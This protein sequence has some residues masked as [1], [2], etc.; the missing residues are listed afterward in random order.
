MLGIK[1][2]IVAAALF[3]GGCT[4]ND[5]ILTGGERDIQNSKEFP[6]LGSSQY[7]DVASIIWPYDTL[8]D[9]LPILNRDSGQQGSGQ[10]GSA[11]N[12]AS[13]Q[14]PSSSKSNASPCGAGSRASSAYNAQNT[15]ENKIAE[16]ER[17]CEAKRLSKAITRF[18]NMYNG[19][20]NTVI[21][22][23][24]RREIQDAIVAASDGLCRDYEAELN[25]FYTKNN[26]LFGG[27]STL[28]GGLGSIVTGAGAA[29]S[30]AGAAGITSGTRSEIN[31]DVFQQQAI[32]IVTNGIEN[33][34]KRILN[35]MA[36]H[37][38]EPLGVYTLERAI[39]HAFK[40]HAACSLIAGLEEAAKATSQGSDVGLAA[41]HKT[42]QAISLIYDDLHKGQPG[43]FAAPPTNTT[44]NSASP[45]SAVNPSIQSSGSN[46]G[47]AAPTGSPD[48]TCAS[49]L[50]MED[51]PVGTISGSGGSIVT[52]ADF[53]LAIKAKA[54]SAVA[55]YK[56]IIDPQI[57]ADMAKAD[58]TSKGL[59]T[60][61]TTLENAMD[62]A[63]SQMDQ[64]ADAFAIENAN[65]TADMVLYKFQINAEEDPKRV[66]SY[67]SHLSSDQ[68]SVSTK[69]DELDRTL[70]ALENIIQSG[71]LAAPADTDVL[72]WVS[73]F[74]AFP[75]SPSVAAP[76][77]PAPPPP[78]PQAST[79]LSLK[80]ASGKPL[81]DPTLISKGGS[82]ALTV[83]GGMTPYSAK[84]YAQDGISAPSDNSNAT[85]NQQK[86][87][88]KIVVKIDANVKAGTK[89]VLN[90]TDSSSPALKTSLKVTTAAVPPL[91]LK[92]SGG[93]ALSDLLSL[94]SGTPAI[95]T[96]SGGT[97]PYDARLFSADG[98]TAPSDGSTATIDQK[99]APT[100]IVIKLGASAKEGTKFVLQVSDSSKPTMKKLQDLTVAVPA[101][102]PAQKA[103]PTALPPVQDKAAE[104]K[105]PPV[106][107]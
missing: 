55:G 31:A 21:A 49:L 24:R 28:L 27:L 98:V 60:D 7:I 33:R 16:T 1:W 82:A 83:S 20:G 19:V 59:G 23:S 80:G 5:T 29:R 56:A 47:N 26:F 41:A 76:P 69:E 93:K 58:S 42:Y 22:K 68:L 37:A 92:N 90:V 45:P 67:L 104:P 107:Q 72:G 10:Q 2:S 11:Q 100:K 57:K 51:T 43:I 79:S 62:S 77:Q 50:A 66:A 81:A 95:I 89:Y 87:A 34:R 44:P 9:S 96:A 73:A 86:A 85:I 102:P 8:N 48:T 36:C 18:D 101:V 91:S 53:A 30:L 88:G 14:R 63:L 46:P 61:L 103:A 71:K 12:A 99:K 84:L 70:S 78:P 54:A 38:D 105:P 13:N 40:Y 106:Q 3:L 6:A 75:K 35:I 39:A 25:S 74:Y 17:Q 4:D 97:V 32:Q 64:L 94:E 15:D 65:T 52:P